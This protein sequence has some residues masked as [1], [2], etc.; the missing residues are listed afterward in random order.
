MKYWI[1]FETTLGVLQVVEE[2]RC[3]TEVCFAEED[4]SE[5]AKWEGRAGE[6]KPWED[7]SWKSKPGVLPSSVESGGCRRDTP[8]LLEARKQLQEY[9]I[10]ERRHFD[11]PLLP[12]GTE[13]Q[14]QVWDALCSIPYG[15]TRSY[16]EI[17]EQVGNPHGCRAVGMAN[18][19]NP[20]AIVIP[21]HRV[22][23]ADG[24]LTGYAGGLDRKR[25][26]LELERSHR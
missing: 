19:H 23:G 1:R 2:N 3:V 7:K 17:A 9:D 8:L 6:A 15:E 5:S 24:S 11:L 4:V 18:H 26:L 20:I 13:F 16:K 12:A 25:Q 14:K 22:M 21:C 10:G